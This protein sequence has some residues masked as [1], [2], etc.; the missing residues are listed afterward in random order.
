VI[1]LAVEKAGTDGAKHADEI[2]G[3]TKDGEKC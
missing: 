2:V 1:A 3:I